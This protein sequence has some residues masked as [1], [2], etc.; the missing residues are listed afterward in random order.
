[1]ENLL[2]PGGWKN[3]ASPGQFGSGFDILHELGWR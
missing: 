2:F 1:M 3:P